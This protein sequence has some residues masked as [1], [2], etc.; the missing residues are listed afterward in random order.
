LTRV[1]FD[2]TRRDFFLPEGKKFENLMFLREIFQTQTIDG[3][4]KTGK[5][6]YPDPS[7]T[8]KTH[9][10]FLNKV[11]FASE[12]HQKANTFIKIQSVVW[13]KIQKIIFLETNLR[14]RRLWYHYLPLSSWFT[15]FLFLGRIINPWNVRRVLLIMALIIIILLNQRHCEVLT[16][17]RLKKIQT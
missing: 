16:M 12:W 13:L 15:I 4:P 10:F 5:K 17:G 8:R 1:H 3:W 2:L 9:F 7:R 6:F 11:N 14:F